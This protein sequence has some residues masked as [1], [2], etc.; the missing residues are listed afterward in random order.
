MVRKIPME[1]KRLNFFK[2]ILPR[3]STEHLVI[4]FNYRYVFNFL[5]M[6]LESHPNSES[7]MNELSE[8]AILSLKEIFGAFM[9]CESKQIASC[10]SD[11]LK[12]VKE[13]DGDDADAESAEPFPHFTSKLG[14]YSLSPTSVFIN[15][16]SLLQY[17]PAPFYKKHLASE[18]NEVVLIKISNGNGW[19][20]VKLTSYGD[21]VYMTKGLY[22]FAVDNQV[23]LGSVCKFEFLKERKMVVH[24]LKE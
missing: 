21:I 22:D 7:I 9:E 13:D 4:H 8:R 16:M 6:L 23:K 3:Y 12:E 18:N 15:W 14:N 17:V 24:I 19:Y 10:E 1:R 11:H 20:E 5:Q 2:L